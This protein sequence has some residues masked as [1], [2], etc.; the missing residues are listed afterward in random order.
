MAERAPLLAATATVGFFSLAGLPPRPWEVGL[1]AVIEETGGIMSYWA[2]YHPPGEPDF[3]HP[4]CFA[5]T[6]PAPEP[7]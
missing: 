4:G 6:L 1:C 2:L 3:H 5:L 7:T